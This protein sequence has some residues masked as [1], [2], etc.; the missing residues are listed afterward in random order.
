MIEQEALKELVER[1]PHSRDL[2]I[3]LHM[4]LA[5]S[6]ACWYAKKNRRASSDLIA[7]GYLGL[8]QAVQWACEGRL[9]DYN[10]TPYIVSTIHRYCRETIEKD[11]TVIVE[12][13]A[14]KHYIVTRG[15]PVSV[16]VMDD[17]STEC[18]ADHGIRVAE[19]M[20]RYCPRHQAVIRLR[21]A[22]YTQTE[23]AGKLGVTQQ[24][25]GRY[26]RDI[27]SKTQ[28]TCVRNPKNASVLRPESYQ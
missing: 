24:M 2:I 7:D 11:H 10:I 19:A 9:R 6:I 23:I 4:P 20:S 26:L 22:G 15:L 14:R 27:K 16:A 8:V 5:R 25:V 18:C 12:R 17:R 1:L 28:D 21:M 13:R 3:E